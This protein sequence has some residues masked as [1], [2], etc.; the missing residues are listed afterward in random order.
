MAGCTANVVLI[1]QTRIYCANAG[2][3]RCV[4]R[5]SNQVIPLSTD[6]KPEDATETARIQAAGHMIIRNRV[7]CSLAVS[8]ALGDWEYKD[9]G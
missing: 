1:T 2:D 8:R 7:D 9:P 6:H 5:D 4:I 3:S